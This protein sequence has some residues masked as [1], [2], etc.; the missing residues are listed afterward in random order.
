MAPVP[1]REG[2]STG[3]ILG[4]IG[5]VVGI[6]SLLAAFGAW[7]YPNVLTRPTSDRERAAYLSQIDGLCRQAG[8]HIAALGPQPPDPTVGITYYAEHARLRQ[9]LLVTWSQFGL[10]ARDEDLVRQILDP[11]ERATIE[12][13]LVSD[14]LRAGNL[15]G[16]DQALLRARDQDVEF[17]Q[18]SRAYG[19]RVCP[20]L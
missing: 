6:A 17:R 8:M 1:Q 19:L 14:S 11:L 12:F 16:A 13:I 18:K 7:L 3:A 20:D 15:Q 10:P 5:A 9:D 4:M 2:H